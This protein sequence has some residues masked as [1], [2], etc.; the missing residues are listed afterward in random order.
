MYAYSFSYISGLKPP[1]KT[2][3]LEKVR[4]LERK[5]DFFSRWVRRGLTKA[6]GKCKKE[7]TIWP[8][9]TSAHLPAGGLRPLF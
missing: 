5:M 6:L 3:V 8:S 2:T 9:T 4:S 1:M 7:T